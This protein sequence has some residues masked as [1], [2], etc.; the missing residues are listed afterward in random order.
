MGHTVYPPKRTESFVASTS[1]PNG[2]PGQEISG[3]IL[4]TMLS[5]DISCTIMSSLER[6]LPSSFWSR[7][8][9]RELT[10]RT[11]QNSFFFTLQTPKPIGSM[12]AIYGNIWGI[13]MVNV[14]IYGIHGSYGKWNFPVSCDVTLN[15]PWTKPI[16][17]GWVTD[18]QAPEWFFQGRSLQLVSIPIGSMYGIYANIG[19]ILMV[20]VTIYSIHG[21][22]GI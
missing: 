6:S 11:S 4:L 5:V 1:V 2:L 10:L 19:G 8:L 21:S 15:D 18:A 22:Y 12:Y 3:D 9:D 7:K 14:T 13:L 17:G 16:L 20:N